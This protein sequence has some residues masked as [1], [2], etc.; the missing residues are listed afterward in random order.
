MKKLLPMI[1]VMT[2][3]LLGCG[4]KTAEHTP[5]LETGSQYAWKAGESPVSPRRIGLVRQGVE[6]PSHAVSE[7]GSYYIYSHCWILGQTP[8]SPWIVYVDHDSDTVIK[9]CGR[10][11]CTHLTT[12]CNAF[13]DGAQFLGYDA[14]HL[15]VSTM[16]WDNDYVDPVTGQK[17]PIAV[18]RLYRMEPDGTGRTE[19]LDYDAF[20]EERGGLFEPG[21]ENL[22]G[23]YCFFTVKY[24][25]VAQPELTRYEYYYYKL[26]GS[27]GEPRLYSHPGYIRYQCGD[28]FINVDNGSRENSY[29]YS[30]WTPEGD[31]L[32]FLLEQDG[33]PGWF[34]DT[35]AWYFR[36]GIVYCQ[37]YGE[38][39]PQ[40]MLDTGL[41][42]EYVADF[43]EDCIV[44]MEMD[45]NQVTDRN[46][47]I[48]NWAYELVETVPLDYEFDAWAVG[49]LLIGETADR[50]I[51]TDDTSYRLPAY[52]IDKA[53]LGTGAV[54]LHKYHLV[55]MEDAEKR[56]QEEMEDQEWFENG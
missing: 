31:S 7:T 54:T 30:A 9:L 5:I 49:F 20:A 32:Q 14:G 26:D 36:D 38:T 11:D 24:L 15:Y 13:V 45:L 33:I 52:Y 25:N 40:V 28:W 4:K 18:F 46:L 27:M 19:V 29:S 55:D 48:Y 3:L 35:Q 41:K 39:E 51:L 17:T 16:S 56:K 21:S 10:P 37:T 1:L 2:L 44:V 34:G 53:E 6:Y 50:L 47:Y 8:P 12:D 43:F 23:G 22:T 42:G